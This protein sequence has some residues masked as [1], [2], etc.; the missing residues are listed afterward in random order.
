MPQT[1]RPPDSA[2]RVASVVAVTAASRVTGLVTPVPSL[3][4][5]VVWVASASWVKGSGL[6]FCVSGHRQQVEAHG[7]DFPA[8]RAV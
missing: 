4:R 7:L 6:R 5:R 3:S 1:I 8:S 2:C